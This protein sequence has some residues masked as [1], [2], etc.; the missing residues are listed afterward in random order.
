M[1]EENNKIKEAEKE[2][3]EENKTEAKTEKVEEKSEKKKIE[4]KKVKKNYAL[5]NGISLPI[6]PKEAASVCDMIRGHNIDEAIKRVEEVL[7]YRRVVRMN[8]REVPNQHGKRVMAGR[9]PQNTCKEFLKLLK[10]LKANAIYNELELE[11]AVL[12]CYANVAS[13]PYK[14]GGA[15]F[16]RCH[17]TLRLDMKKESKNLNLNKQNNKTENKSKKMEAKK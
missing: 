1:A 15:R 12:S 7:A 8:N 3:M 11:N 14:R 16:K 6:S 5:I 9:F 4:V 13:K 10:G 17:V 2:K